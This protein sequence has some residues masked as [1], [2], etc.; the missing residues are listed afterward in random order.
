MATRNVRRKATSTSQSNQPT[1]S[2]QDQ[3]SINKCNQQGIQIAA[4]MIEIV[5]QNSGIPNQS[6]MSC[7]G[8]FRQARVPP[9]THRIVTQ[10]FVAFLRLRQ[11]GILAEAKRHCVSLDEAFHAEDNREQNSQPPPVVSRPWSSNDQ[12]EV[13]RPMTSNHRAKVLPM[14]HPL[15]RTDRVDVYRAPLESNS[16]NGDHLLEVLR[17]FR[18][19]RE[20]YRAM[21]AVRDDLADVLSARGMDK[22]L[23]TLERRYLLRPIAHGGRIVT[24]QLTISG[25]TFLKGIDILLNVPPPPPPPKPDHRAVILQMPHAVGIRAA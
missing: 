21:L 11:A 8:R 1:T 25:E 10:L 4:E 9:E 12:S 16:L 14:P 3:R 6:F 24:W 22:V 18:L 13:S 17:P 7:W 15:A 19:D 23:Q 20:Q 2:N 5:R